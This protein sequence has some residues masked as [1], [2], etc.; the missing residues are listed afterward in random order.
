MK[1][2]SF[3]L[4]LFAGMALYGSSEDDYGLPGYRATY[5][6]QML[7]VDMLSIGA[8]RCHHGPFSFADKNASI[9]KIFYKGDA[10]NISLTGGVRQIKMC[11]G[12]RL[13]P[14]TTTYGVLGS[15]L[16][17]T[18]VDNW[19]WMAGLSL[20]PDIHQ[21]NL[22]KNTRYIASLHGRFMYNKAFGLHVGANVE[23]GMRTV[24]VQPIIGADYTKG[25]WMY[26]AI[27]PIKAGVSYVGLPHHVFSFMIRSIYTAARLQK[28]LS[29]K[30]SVIRYRDTGAEIRWDLSPNPMWNLWVSC[31]Y[32]LSGLLH[33]GNRKFHD[34]N[35]ISFKP[36]PYGQI[37]II[38][39][40]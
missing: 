33:V 23:T 37:G 27:Y 22:I 3:F 9:N 5:L 2:I 18:G 7:D 29:H 17:Y 14:Q 36:A 40:L 15:S 34:R 16:E 8:R 30:P 39:A 21:P 20:Q 6:E 35:G 12:S 10:G 26:Q 11:L 38:L 25:P 1:R 32:T 4:L 24:L 19:K 13:S 28:G 31:G